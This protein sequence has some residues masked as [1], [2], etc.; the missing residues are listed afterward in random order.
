MIRKGQNA[1]EYL[2]L[3][4]QELRGMDRNLDQNVE[5]VEVTGSIP[6]AP[7]IPLQGAFRAGQLEPRR[8]QS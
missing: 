7:T 5:I 1:A 4:R 6:V 2:E 3:A 8:A